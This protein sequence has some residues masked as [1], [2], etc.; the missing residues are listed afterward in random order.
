MDQSAGN[1]REKEDALT[2]TKRA[3]LKSKDFEAI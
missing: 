2:F 3:I 1:E